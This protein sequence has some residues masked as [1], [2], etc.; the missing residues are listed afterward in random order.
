MEN[1]FLKV[2]IEHGLKLLS[3]AWYTEMKITQPSRNSQSNVITGETRKASWKRRDLGKKRRVRRGGWGSI[4]GRGWSLC[5][6]FC[7]FRDRLK[8]EGQALK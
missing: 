2:L 5:R 3:S 6:E 4:Q 7:D 1:S 8:A